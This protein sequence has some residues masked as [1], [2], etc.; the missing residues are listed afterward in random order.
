VS[1]DAA[2]DPA[3]WEGFAVGVVGAAAAL[4]GL[5]VVASSINISRIIESPVALVGLGLTLV[6][7]ALVL[8]VGIV[9]LTPGQS[10]RYVGWEITAA[11][12]LAAAVTLVVRRRPVPAEFR[13]YSISSTI[14][15]VVCA[16]IFVVGGLGCAFTAIG[17]LY[18]VVLGTIV[19]FI[20]GLVN[21]WVDLVE[22]LR[23]NT[24][25]SHPVMRTSVGRPSAH[26]VATARA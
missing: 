21:A 15:S 3:L 25:T 13:G 6:L 7:F 19:A 24:P 18:W 9:L 23:Q 17:G 5:L 14:L 26:S 12:V 4:A 22:V 10:Q 16:G 1:V 11:G 8:V 2:Y 20:V